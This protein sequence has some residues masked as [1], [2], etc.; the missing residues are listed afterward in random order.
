M[1]PSS[2]N[3]LENVKKILIEE[4]ANINE[5]NDDPEYLLSEFVLPGLSNS[6]DIL[7]ALYSFQ[8]RERSGFLGKMKSLVQ[9]KLV[10]IMIGTME[11]QS[12][13]QQKFNDLTVKAIEILIEENRSLKERLKETKFA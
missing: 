8:T 11:K 4:G 3:I 1:I 5:K 6:K 10:N 13:K 2:E 9:R 12:M 7:S